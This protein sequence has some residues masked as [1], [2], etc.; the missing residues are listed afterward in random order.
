MSSCER[1]SNLLWS[2][3]KN[4]LLVKWKKKIINCFLKRSLAAPF[5][6]KRFCILKTSEKLSS[7]I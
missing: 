3:L 6:Y 7:A 5:D 1:T 4:R 2:R